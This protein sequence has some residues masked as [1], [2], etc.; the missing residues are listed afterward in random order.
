MFNLLPEEKKSA[1]QRDYAVRFRIVF[2]FS[3]FIAAVAGLIFLMPSYIIS[4]FR[5]YEKKAELKFYKD[6]ESSKEYSNLEKTLRDAKVDLALAG[7]EQK[8]TVTF[9]NDVVSKKGNSIKINH[10]TV[11]KRAKEGFLITVGGT[12]LTRDAL[13]EFTK[14][15]ESGPYSKVVLPVSNLAKSSNTPFVLNIYGK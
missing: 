4:H 5:E 6:K 10:V 11:D 1:L 3:L 7:E 13:I 15:L 2:S 8:M 9:I 14:R 12:A